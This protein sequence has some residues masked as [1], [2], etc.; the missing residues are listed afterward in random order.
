MPTASSAILLGVF[1]SFEPV[2][3][4]LF[5]RRVG[6]GEFLI[7]NKYLVNELLDL[8]LWDRDMIDYLFEAKSMNRSRYT[9]N[10]V[11]EHK[12][13]KTGIVECTK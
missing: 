13:E 10:K 1:E 5:T 9:L 4:N 12:Y 3:S 7:V 8:G 2:T 11:I 6:Q